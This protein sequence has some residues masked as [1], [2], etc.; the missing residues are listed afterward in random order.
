MRYFVTHINEEEEEDDNGKEEEEKKVKDE[1]E[2][3]EK[4]NGDE[5]LVG[6]NQSFAVPSRDNKVTPVVLVR[7]SQAD[8]FRHNSSLL[9]LVFPWYF[10][11]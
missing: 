10:Q 3:Q 4:E 8:V 1:E 9:T 6:D 11:L 5:V 2:K 7:Y